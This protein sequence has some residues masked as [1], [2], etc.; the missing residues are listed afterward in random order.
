MKNVAGAHGRWSSSTSIPTIHDLFDSED[1]AT[2]DSP[3]TSVFHSIST[4]PR[5]LYWRLRR[6][7]FSLFVVLSI[8]AILYYII[9]YHHHLFPPTHNPSLRYKSVDWRLFAYSQYATDSDYLCNSV[10]VFEALDRLGSKADRILMYPEEWD[11]KNASIPNRDRELLIKARNWYG[12]K[13]LPVDV[14]RFER[15][16]IGTAEQGK[17]SSSRSCGRDLIYGFK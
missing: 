7:R 2:L 6:S 13:L 8:L 3:K 14:K 4:N 17:Y 15:V 11:Y 5:S 1:D 16:V 10:M 9:K 12:A